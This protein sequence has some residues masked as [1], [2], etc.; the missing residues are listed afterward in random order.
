M[1]GEILNKWISK[2]ISKKKETEIVTYIQIPF[3]IFSLFPDLYFPV[4]FTFLYLIVFWGCFRKY[5]EILA[6]K[7]KR[8][9]KIS[10]PKN[11]ILQK[12]II[13]IKQNELTWIKTPYFFPGEYLSS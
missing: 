1:E 13:Q 2:L 10:T 6:A 4:P 5:E 9:L 7:L 12:I 3:W 11:N 8:A